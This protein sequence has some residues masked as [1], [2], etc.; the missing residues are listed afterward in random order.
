MLLCSDL[1]PLKR[2]II[3]LSKQYLSIVTGSQAAEA[4]INQDSCS[5][6]PT[7]VYI[8]EVDLEIIN[9]YCSLCCLSFVLFFLKKGSVSL[10][11]GLQ[12][13]GAGVL[14]TLQVGFE[15]PTL[16]TLIPTHKLSG[17]D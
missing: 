12:P 8:N 11:A 9:V 14:C 2:V 7:S 6:N 1:T 16:G 15:R 17:S 5:S 3:L 13:L 10:T 4:L